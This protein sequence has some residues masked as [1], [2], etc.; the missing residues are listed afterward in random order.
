L[1]A[2][3]ALAGN[4][5]EL[6]GGENGL[7]LASEVARAELGALNLAR[8]YVPRAFLIDP[9]YMPGI[10][11]GQ[12]LSAFDDLRSDPGDAPASIPREGAVASAGADR[13]LIEAGDLIVSP[14]RARGGAGS[15]A[16]VAAT[17]MAPHVV[18]SAGGAVSRDGRCVS[19]RSAGA[20][21]SLDLALPAIGLRLH[22]AAGPPVSV[23][24]RRF[25][26]RFG[27]APPLTA[28]N[29]DGSVIVRPRADSISRPWFLRLSPDQSVLACANG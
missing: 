22:A 3:F 4:V 2:L 16:G 23:Y 28:L 6:S 18:G 21:A 19:F 11:A 27:I 20:G 24:A 13:V 1:I 9:H 5:Y 29:G 25:A 15:V 14:P 12:L 17:G 8:S 10:T 7:R 26:P